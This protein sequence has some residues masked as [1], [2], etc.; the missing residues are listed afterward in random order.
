MH[1]VTAYEV[2]GDLL[3]LALLVGLWKFRIFKREG[4]LFFIYA[5]LYSLMRFGVSF[6]RVDKEIAVGLGMAQIIALGVIVVSLLAFA[7]IIIR[8]PSAPAPEPAS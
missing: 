3:I 4:I 1:F 8:R 5:F 2:L 6:L 7:A